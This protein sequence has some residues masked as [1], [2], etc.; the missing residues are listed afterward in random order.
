M[1]GRCS[2]E[3][4]A[5]RLACATSTMRRVLAGASATASQRGVESSPTVRRRRRRGVEPVERR[6]A[7][8]EVEAVGGS[9]RACLRRATSERVGSPATG[10]KWKIPPPSLLSSTIVS[11][12]PSR[13]AASS[14]PMSWASATSPISSTTGPSPAAAAPNADETVP[15]I[16]LAP[17]LES[18]RGGS[19]RA[20]KNVSTSR[21]GIEEA[22]NSVASAAA[23]TRPSSAATSGSD[24]SSPS[25]CARALAGARRRR[26][27]RRR[28]T[29][30]R[31]GLPRRRSCSSSSA[32]VGR[33]TRIPTTRVRVLPGA[34][35]VDRDLRRSSSPASQPRSGLEVGR[36]PTRITSSGRCALGER[37]VAQQRVVVGDRG[38]PAARARQRI[39]EQREAGARG[40]AGQLARGDGVALGAGD[41]HA[42]A[43][44]VAP[45]GRSARG[46]RHR[47]RT[48]GRS[49]SRALASSGSG[50]VEHER[51]AQREVQVHRARRTV[52]GGRARAAGSPRAA[53]AS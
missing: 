25:A 38:R 7:S 31:S 20:G 37:G 39:G 6:D 5:A 42:A 34:L 40:E 1:R 53:A 29:R 8:R 50:R 44:R 30:A 4:S 9:A 51:L 46:R 2:A 36:S 23:A 47:T 32:R 17:R 26:R 41:D 19:S 11:F 49:P 35:G 48:Y 24:S 22:T 14:P 13:A 21:T 28:A 33:A 12:S 18:T 27:A 10:R 15:S 16:P 43:E 52:Q 3:R 45:S